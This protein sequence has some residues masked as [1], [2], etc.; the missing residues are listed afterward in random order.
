MIRQVFACV[1]LCAL[2]AP[3]AAQESAAWPERAFVTIDV[4]FQVS[5][6]SLS[7][8]VS[9]A[10]AFSK[11]EKD[12]FNAAYG[13][14]KGAMF[15]IGGGVR[16]TGSFGVGVTGSWFRRP[17][18][19]TFDLSVPNPTSANK[20]RSLTGTATSLNRQEIGT[21]IQALYALPLGKKGRVMLSAGPSVFSVKQDV[22]R[23]VEFDESAGFTSIKLNQAIIATATNTAVGWNVGADLTW[24][25]ASHFGIGSTTRYSRANV[26]IDPGSTTASVSR[27]IDVRA[28]GLQIGGGVR[29]LF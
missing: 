3:A 22:V 20:P 27:S 29:V 16:L 6:N 11:T 21:H 13:S 28:G 4:P 2:A 17:S 9:L 12:V 24:V 10:D 26:T 23:S 7:E 5:S 1:A 15:D 19:A 25:L 18:D 8:S 14:T